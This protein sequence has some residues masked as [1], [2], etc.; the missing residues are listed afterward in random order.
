MR[1]ARRWSRPRVCAAPDRAGKKS[2]RGLDSRTID[3]KKVLLREERCGFKLFESRPEEA[4]SFEAVANRS[5]QSQSTPEVS[6]HGLVSSRLEW[7]FD[8][9]GVNEVGV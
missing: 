5:R 4:A 6:I 7:I 8:N 1:L 3:D 9:E 2:G